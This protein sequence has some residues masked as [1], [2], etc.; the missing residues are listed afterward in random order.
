MNNDSIQEIKIN[1]KNKAFTLAEVLVT[2]MIIGV[3]AS[4]TIPTLK[5]VSD[6]KAYVAGALKAYSELSS[7][8]KSLKRT[9]GPIS[10]WTSYSSA[11]AA[12]D[13]MAKYKKIMPSVG[14]PS[15]SYKIQTLNNEDSSLGSGTFS[16]S[17]TTITAADGAIYNLAFIN[18]CTAA[19]AASKACFR[20]VV[21]VN[22]T[23]DPNMIG[24]DVYA[25]D[26]MKNG[27]VF[28]A[29]GKCPPNKASESSD[30]DDN[31]VDNPTTTPD[32]SK[33]QGESNAQDSDGWGCTARLVKEKDISW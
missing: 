12:N 14:V 27:D 26:V 19:G 22:G 1:M 10:M 9:E 33:G 5:K 28:P 2:L 17:N 15:S 21:D 23:K 20:M 4:I 3:I 13:V 31:K 25:F 16:N 29:E 11:S 6:E 8:T 18:N 7:A 24:V 30:D 32:V